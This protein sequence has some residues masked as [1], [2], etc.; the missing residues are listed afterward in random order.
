MMLREYR[1]EDCFELAKLFFD[2]V[3]TV[4]LKDYTKAQV[5]VWASGNVD[6]EAWDKS[7]KNHYTVISE[8]KGIITG[9]GDM[10]NDGYLDRLYVH[11]E[12]QGEGIG[13]LIVT[14]LEREIK[15]RYGVPVFTVFSS[16]TAKPF[17][18]KR[19]YRVEREQ[20]VVRNGI[21]LTN[22][23]MAKN[24]CWYFN[25]GQAQINFYMEKKV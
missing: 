8:D 22:Y 9:F 13:S 18:E 16:I 19:G 2:T 24:Y 21:R 11:K 10:S 20:E 12:H 5:D 15:T 25:R 17:F 4:N 7:F 23:R 3:H 1:S 14:E 6:I